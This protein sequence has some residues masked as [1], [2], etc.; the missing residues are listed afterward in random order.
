MIDGFEMI[1]AEINDH[2]RNVLVPVLV[3]ILST[4]V[5]I[6]RA[7]KNG[8]I[9]DI[10]YRETRSMPDAS[11]IRKMINHIRITGLVPCLLASS[12]GYYVAVSREEVEAYQ[13]S[14]R[15]RAGAIRCVYET[16]EIQKTERFLPAEGVTC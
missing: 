2:E 7:L 12:H 10:L 15:S 5:G 6:D 16:L 14:L 3:R 9:R 11:R 1:T 8:Q 4:C 13:Q